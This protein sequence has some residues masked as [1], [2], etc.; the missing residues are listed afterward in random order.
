MNNSQIKDFIHQQKSLFWFIPEDKKEDVSIEVLVE[1]ILNYGDINAIRQLFYLLGVD[2]V[3]KHFYS[4]LNKSERKKA[5]LHEL[6][7]H[8]F[9][10]FFNKYA[11]RDI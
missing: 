4:L 7:I 3:A 5:N 1:T 9:T 8:F 10:L 6:T 2:E 11:H